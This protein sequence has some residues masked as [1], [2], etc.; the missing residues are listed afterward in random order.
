MQ[1][2]GKVKK[3]VIFSVILIFLFV[4]SGCGLIGGTNESNSDSNGLGRTVN[5][6]KADSYNSFNQSKSVLDTDKLNSLPTE[7]TSIG[8]TY[9]Y[10]YSTSDMST[11]NSSENFGFEISGG[12]KTML[13]SVS[14]SFRTSS[15]TDYSSYLSTYFY[16]YEK[17]VRKNGIYFSNYR[18]NDYSAMLSKSYLDSL[19]D[20]LNDSNSPDYSEF[21]DQYGTHL[22]VSGIYGGK[23]NAYYSMSTS[24]VSWDSS[25][26]SDYGVKVKASILSGEAEGT[27]KGDFA[28]ELG[29]SEE[30]MEEFFSF[31]TVGGDTYTG[32]SIS[33]F[34]E[35]QKIWSTSFNEVKS[36]DSSSQSIDYVL[37][38]Y[39]DDGLIALWDMLPAKYDLLKDGMEDAFEDYYDEYMNSI[40]SQF[41]YVSTNTTSK[42]I[43]GE[44]RLRVITD[45]GI[46]GMDT[47]M[48]DL[49][50]LDLTSLSTYFDDNYMFKF[51]ITLNMK[52]KDQ[53]YQE[54]WL[55]NDF[56][57]NYPT[58]NLSLSRQQVCGNGLITGKYDIS[59]YGDELLDI[60]NDIDIV[61]YASGKDIRNEMYLKYDAHGNE[62]DTWNLLK[63]TVTVTVLPVTV[64]GSSN[65]EKTIYDVGAWGRA[66]KNSDTVETLDFSSYANELTEDYLY[67]IIIGVNMKENED[68]RQGFYLYSD[69][70]HLD[71]RGETNIN[72]AIDY[73]LVSNMYDFDLDP[74]LNLFSYNYLYKDQS[75]SLVYITLQARG[76]QL[77]EIMYLNFDAQGSPG[78]NTWTMSAIKIYVFN[79][80]IE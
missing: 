34:S 16:S 11:L 26:N 31:S 58:D 36:S 37:V 24:A 7:T 23:L 39:A 1:L 79:E 20:L 80:T 28:E 25:K 78:A 3:T 56:N 19:D 53:G 30:S 60:Y 32:S 15:T 51:E 12:Y 63:T 9:D 38:D 47:S 40:S 22:I 52:E 17:V 66:S 73:G 59:A 42:T 2:G 29:I 57:I 77:N 5:V 21:F 48:D 41:E 75:E 35:S 62:A 27:I 4:V 54:V 72:D 14:S 8:K 13:G 67:T 49:D 70:T 46:F 6:V 44:S 10:G 45:T 68:G 33:D 76:D 55:Y 50:K 43:I 64:V 74:Y 71:A 61:L 18:D 65:T 69:N